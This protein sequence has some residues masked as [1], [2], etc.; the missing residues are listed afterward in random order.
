MKKVTFK[1][2]N[3]NQPSL[4][5]PS[6]EELIP[7]DHL[8]CVV[9]RMVDSIDITPLLV[10]YKGGETSSYHPRMMLKVLVYAYAE[11]IFLSR[12]IAKG[13]RENVNFMWISG[14]NKPDFRTINLFRGETMKAAVREVFASV[15]ELLVEGGYVKMENYFVDGTKV[16]ANANPHK[17]VWAKKTKKYKDRLRAQIMGL[18]DEI[19]KVNQAEEEAYGDEDLEELGG[20]GGIDA[21]KL[22]RKVDEL[23]QRLQQQSE[24]KQ[25]K[26]AV[27]TL[28]K[29]HLP[30]LEKYEAQ[31]QILAGRSSYSKTDPDATCFRMKEDRAAEKPLPRPAYN[32]QIGTEG[33]FIIGYS[34]HQ[35]AGDPG[36][37]IPHMQQQKFPQD[38]K[39]QNLSG[40]AAYGSEEN[41]AY[42]EEQQIGNHLKYNTFYRE[43]HPPRK[44]ELIQ[45][46]SFRVENLPYD[47]DKDQFTCPAKHPLTYR[48]TRP[49]RTE[50]GYLT[51]RR[52]YE[53]SE[54]D[55]CPL[56]PQCTKAEGNRRI[57]ISFKLREYRQQAKANLLSEQG[58]ALR[59]QRG[60]DVEGAF[61]NIKHNMGVRRFKLRGLKKVET[62]WGLLAI[63]HNLRKLAAH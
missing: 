16:E 22:Q 11:K 50:N 24:N 15:L 56:K 33:Q 38:R 29:K 13:L 17:V 5:P 47:P 26:K 36:C 40:D 49:Y 6:L 45:K 27:K 30:R 37:F 18:L 54:C 19:E 23:N 42:L 35:R 32:V 43:T 53:C 51:E 10:K 60:P 48:E 39:V 4:L 12:R 31:E 2:Y 25:L 21:E 62:E 14:G 9:N 8:V 7:E 55:T 34:I 61:G 20:K 28:E 59:K 58:I 44:E 52:F 1:Q 41:Y 57:Q 63:A 3:M 46:A